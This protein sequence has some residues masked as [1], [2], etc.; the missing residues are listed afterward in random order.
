LTCR[1]TAAQLALRYGFPVVSKPTEKYVAII[2][3]TSK[4]VT[5]GWSENDFKA[6]CGQVKA[7][8]W[9]SPALPSW[10]QEYA[11]L[12]GFGMPSAAVRAVQHW[13]M[14]R[15]CGGATSIGTL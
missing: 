10:P 8:L 2:E 14:H 9:L 13:L 11:C 4:E 7:E 12:S 3:L 5:T 1:Y 6:Y 15:M